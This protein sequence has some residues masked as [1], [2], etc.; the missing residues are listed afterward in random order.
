MPRPPANCLR[1]VCFHIVTSSA[2]DGFIIGVIIAN[3]GVM[4]CDYWG[5]ERDVDNFALYNQVMVTFAY[6]YYVEFCLKL[7]ALGP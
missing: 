7:T 6:I 3:V 4:A 5:I 2:F 1:A